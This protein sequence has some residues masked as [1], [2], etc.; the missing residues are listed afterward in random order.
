MNTRKLLCWALSL[1]LGL[2]ACGG[3]SAPATDTA[4]PPATL[5]SAP[6]TAT[7]APPTE[8]PL[9]TLAPTETETTPATETPLSPEAVSPTPSVEPIIGAPIAQLTAGQVITLT[10]INMYDANAGWAIGKAAPESDDHLFRTADGGQ[11]WKEVTPP[12][13]LDVAATFGQSAAGFFLSPARAWAAY[14][15]ATGAAISAPVVIWLTQDGGVS[16]KASTPLPLPELADFYQISDLRFVD[17]QH[18]WA[19][20]HLGVGMSHDYVALYR[21]ENG[22]QTWEMLIHPNADG[23]LSMSCGKTDFGFADVKRGWVLGDC[24]G[25]VP[26]GPYFY[27]TDDGGQT[28][29]LVNLPAPAD[30]PDLYDPNKFDYAC[31]SAALRFPTPS[32]GALMVRCLMF[33]DSTVKSW[34][35]LTSDAGQNWSSYVMPGTYNAYPYYGVPLTFFTA[36]QGWMLNDGA[37]GTSQ[38]HRTADGGQTWSLLKQLSWTGPMDFVDA[39]TGWA[40]AHAGEAVAL[41]KTVDGGQKWNEIKPVTAP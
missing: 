31:G 18:G 21:T 33:A 24:G 17:A 37:D 29:Q 39:Q 16:W 34:L 13:P 28:W 26:G 14:S 32:N 35:Y 20:M 30:A 27:Q 3:P 19:L 36:A 38:L 1:V 6:P 8:T 10:S 11:T 41:V 23:G 9:P 40:I 12:Q 4:V 15:D 25:V 5:T 7:A 2:T 22:G